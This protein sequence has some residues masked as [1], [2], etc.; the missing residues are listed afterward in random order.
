M[1]ENEHTQKSRQDSF[2][3]DS[4][5]GGGQDGGSMRICTNPAITSAQP[6]AP[7]PSLS[8]PLRVSPCF[9]ALLRFV[10]L[11]AYFRAFS[12]SNLGV[13]SLPPPSTLALLRSLQDLPA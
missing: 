13:L 11:R 8:I 1:L 3:N 7:S 12:L 10:L 2:L 6:F 9:P 4:L 5:R